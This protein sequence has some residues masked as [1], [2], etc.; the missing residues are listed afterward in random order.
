MKFSTLFA[1]ALFLFLF[2][3]TID[4]IESVAQESAEWE[5]EKLDQAVKAKGREV[6]FYQMRA[7]PFGKI[8]ASARL[9]ALG[10]MEKMPRYDDGLSAAADDA[11]RQLGPYTVGGRVRSIAVHPS[12]GN[13]LWIGAADGG[14]WKTTDA[15]QSWRPQMQEENAIAMGAIAVDP[16]NPDIL[17]AGTGELSSN[18]DAYTG[19]GIFKSSDGGD[20]WR[21]IGL[22]TVGAFSHII[23][24]AD[25]SQIIYAGATKNNDGFYRST[26]GG[27]TWTRTLEDPVS[28]IRV[29]PDP[30]S[31]EKVWVALMGGGI[32]YSEDG[33][34]T[35]T[36]RSQGI[37]GSGVTVNRMSI[38]ISQSNPSILYALAYE[39][40]GTSTQF[41]RIYKTTNGGVSWNRVF[42]ND[43]GNDFLSNPGSPSQGWY[44]NTIAIKPDDPDIVIAGGVRMV[45]TQ[46]GGDTWTTTG[47][48]VHP[49][50][51]AM[52]FSTTDPNVLYEGNDGGMVISQNAGSSFSVINNDLAISQ[53]YA[54]A[55]DQR[56]DDLTYGGTQDNGTLTT[57]SPSY[58]AAILGG[59]GF[60][61][62]IDPD[63][64]NVIYAERQH[65]QMYRIENNRATRLYT[66]GD[67]P[68]ADDLALWSA[69]LHLDP[70]DAQRLYSGRHK[71]YVSFNPR[72][73]SSAVE[74]FEASPTV[75]G[76]ISAFA[77]SPHDS[78]VIILGSARGV[79]MRTTNET[80]DWDDLSF[81][82]G[83]PNRAVTDVVFSRNDPNTVY[84]AYSGFFSDHVYKSTDLGE[85]WVSIS[86]SLPDIP[87]NA[88]ELHPDDERIVFAGTDLGMFITLDGGESWAVYNEG[89]PRVAVIDLKV[90]LA[91]GTLRAGTHGRSMFERGI[92]GEPIE[93]TPSITSPHG[94]E[95]WIGGTPNLLGW[96]GFDDPQGVHV[97]YSLDDGRSWRELGSGVIGST[98]RWNTVSAAT[99]TAR[100]RV[101]GKSRPDQV[102]ISNTFT[103]QEFSQGALLNT[104][105]KPTVPY[106]IAFD[107]EH[108]WTTDF[109][110]NTLLKLDP[111]T[112][113]AVEVVTLGAEAG[114]SLFTDLTYYPPRQTLFIHRLNSTTEPNAG[115]VIMEVFRDG[116]VRGVWNSPAAYPI[117]LAWLGERNPDSEFSFLV[118]SDRDGAQRY[119]FY[120]PDGFVPGSG[121]S[122]SFF[123]GRDIIVESGPRGL[124]ADEGALWQVIT[125][126]TGGSLQSANA[127]QFDVEDLSPQDPLC[128]VP[129]SSPQATTINGRGIE[130]DDRDG[131]L[132]LTDFGGNL[133]KIA[134]CYTGPGA[135]DEGSP[136]DSSRSSVDERWAVAGSSGLSLELTGPNPFSRATSIT[137]DLRSRD[138]V[139]ITLYDRTGRAVSRIADGTYEAGS[140]RLAIAPGGLLPSGEYLCEVRTLSGGRSLVRLV[141][142]R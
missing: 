129:L 22:T 102:A 67:F 92:G 39:T 11:W 14:V 27:E 49:D 43:G 54:I 57:E 138:Q 24:R 118:A 51:H 28:D 126:F 40:V 139:T 131:S 18:V 3:G 48:S 29:S 50:H 2:C 7:W 1:S 82:R 17:Y 83:L 36:N 125:D 140:H 23:V 134:S 58:N 72:A 99:H 113:D 128:E 33:G 120:E 37:G 41:S 84:I 109:G 15:G 68:V 90:H 112:L 98:F 101:T 91:S 136:I 34:I 60:Y 20:S 71:L 124:A 135:S 115:G 88:L 79:V 108:L 122:P 13:T 26:D 8:P 81:G 114:D 137:F 56:E 106:G 16:N 69:P 105:S 141:Y 4:P 119:Y 111:E 63:N 62:A 132:W 96:G 31:P 42:N 100:I 86:R 127:R 5:Y 103:I 78:K 59:D 97:D 117:G 10:E 35:F 89:L 74:W 77:V 123:I 52:A 110:G 6:F 25:N 19:A 73:S 53:F 93:I 66:T 30:G 104:D 45:R 65:G 70:N 94:G 85:S 116:R 75:P 142:L 46:N 64:E 76:N 80:Q 38:D 12:D 133:Y 55:V 130:L 87:V 32:R 61:V 9:A 107:G 121:A 95:V 44:N 21:P 47:S